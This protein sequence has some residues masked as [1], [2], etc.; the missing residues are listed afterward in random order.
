MTK[1]QAEDIE[2]QMRGQA[3]VGMWFHYRRFQITASNLEELKNT[4]IRHR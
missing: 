2:R 1:C 4:E 3:E